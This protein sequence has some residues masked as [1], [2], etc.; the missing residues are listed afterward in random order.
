MGK[1]ELFLHDEKQFLPRLVRAALV[2]VQFE[3][4]HPFL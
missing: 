2:H 4:I 3:T 1:F